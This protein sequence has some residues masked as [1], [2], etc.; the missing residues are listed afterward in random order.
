MQ[1]MDQQWDAAQSQKIPGEFLDRRMTDRRVNDER[2]CDRRVSSDGSRSLK[3]WVRSL[4]KPRMGVDRRKQGDRRR[5]VE[6]VKDLRSLL[7]ADEIRDLL[8]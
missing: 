4:T 2:R 7:T 6:P 3:A 5:Q 1:K 8:R